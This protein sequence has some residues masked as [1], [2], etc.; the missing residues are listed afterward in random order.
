MN[1]NDNLRIYVNSDWPSRTIKI[2]ASQSG[3]SSV[4]EHLKFP[5][6]MLEIVV[7]EGHRV[8]NK[9]DL[10]AL[11]VHFVPTRTASWT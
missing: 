5:T 6:A 7:F 4:A 2:K 10:V 9:S 11:E 8:E 3:R 1:I